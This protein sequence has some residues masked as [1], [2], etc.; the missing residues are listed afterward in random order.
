MNSKPTI[1][2][3]A[4]YKAKKRAFKPENGLRDWQDD[5]E[6]RCHIDVTPA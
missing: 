5:G 3:A 4:Y 2:E 1:A 6:I